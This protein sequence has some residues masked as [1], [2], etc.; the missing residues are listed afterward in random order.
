VVELACEIGRASGFSR[1]GLAELSVA[2]LLHDIGKIRVPDSILN[3]PG[4]LTAGEREVIA[5]HPILG[6]EALIRVAG[7]EVVAAL[8]RYHHER[9]DGSGYPDGLSGARIPR[10]SRIIAVCDAYSA[11][12]SD[13]PYRDAMSQERAFSELRAGAGW[14]FDAEVVAQL[15]DLVSRRAAA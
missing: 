15:E 4:S 11:M 6:A 8:V 9:W 14:Q 2:A 3:K 13:R 1:A 12:T 5:Q 10:A 7:L